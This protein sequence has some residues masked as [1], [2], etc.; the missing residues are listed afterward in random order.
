MNV[1]NTVNNNKQRVIKIPQLNINRNVN[2]DNRN[3]SVQKKRMSSLPLNTISDGLSAR[4]NND[5]QVEYFNLGT[6]NYLSRNKKGSIFD[7][8]GSNYILSNSSNKVNRKDKQKI[9]NTTKHH[10][11]INHPKQNNKCRNWKRNMLSL[12]IGDSVISSF[13]PLSSI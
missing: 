2:C 5:K 10:N 11:E 13:S 3:T 4:Y 12:Q 6:S 7:N 8:K 1:N 9:Y